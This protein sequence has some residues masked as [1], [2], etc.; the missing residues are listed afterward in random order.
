MTDIDKQSLN[1]AQ[2][3]AQTLAK[4]QVSHVFFIDAVL[5]NT[6]VQM[7][8]PGEHAVKRVLAHSE[9]S[10]A[11]RSEEHTSELQSRGH[12]VCR[13]LLEKKKKQNKNNSSAE[14]TDI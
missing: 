13:L 12:L 2:W 14:K 3:L 10:A 9:K 11:Y 8:I 5:R 7:G 6:L 1:G 4:N